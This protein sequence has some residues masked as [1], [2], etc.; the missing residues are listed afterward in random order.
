MDQT[1]ERQR[2]RKR[3]GFVQAK[4]LRR[5]R[6]DYA[7]YSGVRNLTTVTLFTIDSCARE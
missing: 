6:R 3:E 1:K 7:K 4:V 5:G 2:E